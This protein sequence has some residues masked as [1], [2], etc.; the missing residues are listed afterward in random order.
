M[1]LDQIFF[2]FPNFSDLPKLAA[3][4]TTCLCHRPEEPEGSD[5]TSTV[6]S[7]DP[8]SN[9][10]GAGAPRTCQANRGISGLAPDFSH[11]KWV[12]KTMKTPHLLNEMDFFC[13]RNFI[14]EK[15]VEYFHFY[16]CAC[17]VGRK[18][19]HIYSDQ[20]GRSFEGDFTMVDV[21][22]NHVFPRLVSF[23][24]LFFSTEPRLQEK[25]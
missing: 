20:V 19:S 17:K 6:A 25:G 2:I 15:L 21:S 8:R 1:Y 18:L 16:R 22:K 24:C 10:T 5:E 3:P 9:R 4:T 11:K 13:L 12:V 23:H 7:E 14:F